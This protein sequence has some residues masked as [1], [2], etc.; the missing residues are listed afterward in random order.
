M[1]SLIARS[2]HLRHLQSA[3]ARW[4]S[5]LAKQPDKIMLKGL[6][7]HAYHGAAEEV[8][9]PNEMPLRLPESLMMP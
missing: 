2:G 8:G 1:R 3:A 5:E 4:S 6:V 9:S 7:F